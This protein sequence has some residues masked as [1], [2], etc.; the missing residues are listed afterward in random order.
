MIAI[1]VM[2]AFTSAIRDFFSPNKAVEF[3]FNYITTYASSTSTNCIELISD[4]LPMEENLLENIF[5]RNILI[6][7]LA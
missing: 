7:K 5:L 4:Q 3:N 2:I 1:L 6:A